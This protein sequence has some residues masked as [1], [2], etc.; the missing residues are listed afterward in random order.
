MRFFQS[1]LL[2]VSALASAALAQ[3]DTLSFTNVPTSVTVGNSYPI[4]WKTSDTTSPITILLRK[5][6]SGNLLT[7]STLTSTATGTAYTWIPDKS[8]V[9]GSDYALQITQGTQINYSG[10]ISLSGGSLSA[11]SSSASASA[12]SSVSASSSA[13]AASVS[14]S[15]LSTTAITGNSTASVTPSVSAA[16]TGK[17]NST[18]STATLSATKIT[19]AITSAASTG[20]GASGTQTAAQGAPTPSGAA[21]QLG[22]SPMALIF[23]AVAAMAYLN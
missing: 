2:A 15:I 12:S 9:D 10:Q 7:I 22:S 17:G 16:S 23:G 18:I 5:G 1:A 20:A 4:E 13:S 6:P 3:S 11:V 19:S 14:N 8:L 21:G